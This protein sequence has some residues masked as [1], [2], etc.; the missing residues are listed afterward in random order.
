MITAEDAAR[1]LLLRRQAKDDILRY[2]KAI[3]VPGR[4][5]GNDDSDIFAP[6]ETGI[7]AHQVLL[8]RKLEEVARKRHGRLMVMMPPGSSKS[9]Y[10]SVVFPSKYLGEEPGRR[11]IMASYGSDLAQKFGRK[12]R[13]IIQQP[14]YRQIFGASL[15]KE[16]G[17]VDQFALTNGSEYMAAGM[18]SGITGNRAG[19]IGIDDPLRGRSD[20]Q[21]QTVRDKIWAAYNDDVLTR[22]ILGG[23]VVIVNTRWHEDDLCGRILPEN[24]S[25]ESG[26]IQCRDG[27]GWDVICLMARCER[28]DDPLGRKVGEYLWPEWFDA[29]HWAM[30]ESN[31]Q[32]W[33]SLFQQ[34]PSAPEGEFFKP[35]KIPVIDVMPAGRVKWVRG[36]DFASVA[37]GGDFTVGCKLGILD[38]G[39]L[40]IADVVRGQWGPDERDARYKAVTTQDGISCKVSIP[41]DPGQAGKTQVLYMTRMLHGYRIASSPE[42]GD[43]VTRAEPFAAQVNVGNVCMVRGPWNARLLD[44]MRMFP[45]GA[46]DDQVDAMTR[47]YAELIAPAAPAKMVSLSIMGR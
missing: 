17:A 19:L 31:Q 12:T 11:M 13:S 43:K 46:H 21:S 24:W 25:G 10:A 40:V 29:K 45:N 9:T 27:F 30:H 26:L 37:G 8:L 20:A 38:D 28:A 6:V 18:L 15:S 1:E 44:E 22:L 32:S 47:A 4:P 41:Q 7:S 16:S 34:R 5:V 39:R 33:N 35:D 23:S 14:R 3:D 42:S 36:W 2:V